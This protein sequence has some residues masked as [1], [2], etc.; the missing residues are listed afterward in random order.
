[1]GCS[2]DTPVLLFDDKGGIG[3]LGYQGGSLF[4]NHQTRQQVFCDGLV[5]FSDYHNVGTNDCPFLRQE[6]VV[7][8]NLGLGNQ[9]NHLASDSS[10]HTSLNNKSFFALIV[11]VVERFLCHRSNRIRFFFDFWLCL[12]NWL[13][14]I[15]VMDD[16]VVA[17]SILCR[18]N[19]VLDNFFA[20]TC[21]HKK[22]NKMGFPY[23]F[24]VQI[25]CRNVCNFSY[26]QLYQ[27]N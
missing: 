5:D 13:Y 2:Y 4:R 27:G 14:S 18:T 25:N 9:G 24:L 12:C 20:S 3:L 15:F 10:P 17:E 7:C 8:A 19:T 16:F 6:A 1:M 26:S 21:L 22:L 23:Q 11:C